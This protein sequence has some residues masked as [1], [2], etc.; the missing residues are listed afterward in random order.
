MRVLI[1]GP[2][3]GSRCGQANRRNADWYPKGSGLRICLPAS[4][5]PSF[6]FFFLPSTQNSQEPWNG[7]KTTGLFKLA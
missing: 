7:V 4:F 6:F 1:L 2:R 5:S 3:Q